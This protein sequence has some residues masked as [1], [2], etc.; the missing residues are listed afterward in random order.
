LANNSRFLI[1]PE[2]HVPNLASRILSLCEKRLPGDWQENFGHPLVLLETFVDPQ[3]FQG[4][5]YKAAN[6]LHV[7][8]TKGFRRHPPGVQCQGPIPQNGFP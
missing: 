8:E 1:L 6:W 3:R 2:G 4:T 7:G 5:V